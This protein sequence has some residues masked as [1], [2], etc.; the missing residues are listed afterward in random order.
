MSHFA[1]SLESLK[2]EQSAMKFKVHTN[3]NIIPAVNTVLSQIS[4]VGANTTVYTTLKLK[5]HNGYRVNQTFTSF[6]QLFTVP[7]QPDSVSTWSRVSYKL[8]KY[9]CGFCPDY[10]GNLQGSYLRAGMDN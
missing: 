4:C 10:N 6:L 7:L 3:R 9:L 1:G 8:S 5:L 2:L